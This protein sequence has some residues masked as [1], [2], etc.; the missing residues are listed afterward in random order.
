MLRVIENPAIVS[1]AEYTYPYPY[2]G[3]GLTVTIDIDY[4]PPPD[5][6]GG[7]NDYR[8]ASGVSLTCQVTGGSGT[9]M[10]NW[11]STCTG[12][13]RNCFVPYKETQTI[14]RSGLRS[15]DSG[16]HTCTATHGGLC[17]S[18]TIDMNVVGE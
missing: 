9:V 8:A 12:P 5:F 16:N 11:T 17:G 4:T 3:I 13:N 15:T 14:S 10:Y 7:P 6:V 2:T 1:R 18:A